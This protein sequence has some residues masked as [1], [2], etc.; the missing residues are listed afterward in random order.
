M[1][2]VLPVFYKKKWVIAIEKTGSI[3]KIRQF[4]AGQCCDNQT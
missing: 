2:G 3:R 4:P 1:L